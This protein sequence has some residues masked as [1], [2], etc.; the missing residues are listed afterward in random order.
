MKF[1]NVKVLAFVLIAS[2]FGTQSTLA[3]A[4]EP[5]YCSLRTFLSR[6]VSL[7]QVRGLTNARM[8]QLGR[9]RLTGVAVGSSD[10]RILAALAAKH[11]ATASEGYCTWYLNKGDD[12]AEEAFNHQYVSNPMFMLSS[13]AASEY[14]RALGANFDPR[15]PLSFLSCIERHGYVA[16]GCNGMKHRGPSVVGMLL[17]F[18]GCTPEHASEI[19]N[20]VW[21]LNGVRASV[22]HAILEHAY[23]AGN[24]NPAIR[25]RFAR[26]FS[27]Q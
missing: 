20:H 13:R 11:Q 5:A 19:V 8:F 1:C 4:A 9:A 14:W 3:Q 27:A 23:H 12:S 21:G 18:S 2:V 22:R 15:S 7:D 24:A 10:A 17:A 6:E 26:V 16:M 25:T